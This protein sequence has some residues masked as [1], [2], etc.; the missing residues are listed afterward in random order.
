MITPF[1]VFLYTMA[2]CGSIILAFVVAL[3]VAGIAFYYLNRY[4]EK[5][6]GNGR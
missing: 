2:F 6:V 4:V 1:D 5:E 3:L